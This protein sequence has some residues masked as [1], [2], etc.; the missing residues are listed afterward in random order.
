MEASNIQYDQIYINNLKFQ[1]QCESLYTVLSKLGIDKKKLYLIDG[2]TVL[3]AKTLIVPAVPYI[4]SLNGARSFPLWL[5]TFIHDCFLKKS[6]NASPERIY[7]PDPK[8][9]S[10]KFSMSQHLYSFSKNITFKPFTSKSCRS[11]S[12][13]IFFTMPKSSLDLTALA[14]QILSFANREL[15]SLKSTTLLPKKINAA[16]IK[17]LLNISNALT[18]RSTPIPS[19]NLS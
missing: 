2:D 9:P 18:I 8:P 19:L 14:L 6:T 13:P 11:Q 15:L 10:E 16:F 5:K 3:Q 1:W 17:L 4:P 7:I 12:K